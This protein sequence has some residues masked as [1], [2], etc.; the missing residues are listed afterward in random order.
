M[1]GLRRVGRL[2]LDLSRIKARY[3]SIV[4]SI[5]TVGIG[6]AQKT[7]I[8]FKDGS[9]LDIWFSESGRYSF[10]WERQHIDGKLFRFDNAPHHSGVKTFPH[11][12]H[13]GSE[14]KVTESWIDP[15]PDRAVLQVLDFIK[16]KLSV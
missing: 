13:N 16:M 9:Y 3:R 12:L 6:T 2:P 8:L 4:A 15:R 5:E 10:H 7:R 14:E 11:H 1:S